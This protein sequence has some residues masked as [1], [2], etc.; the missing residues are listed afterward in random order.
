MRASVS[1]VIR[2]FAPNTFCGVTGTVCARKKRSSVSD[3]L[4]HQ[5]LLALVV[6]GDAIHSLT[7][8]GRFTGVKYCLFQ[9]RSPVWTSKLSNR[10]LAII[11]EGRTDPTIYLNVRDFFDLV[12]NGL[13]RGI[14]SIRPVMSQVCCRMR[15]SSALSGAR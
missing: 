11:R 10:L 14:D 9:R 5:S 3:T 2:R 13:E 8:Q 12:V 4:D 1:C 7:E 6:E 15:S